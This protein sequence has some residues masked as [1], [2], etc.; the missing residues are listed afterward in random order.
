MRVIMSKS[1]VVIAMSALVLTGCAAEQ[2]RQAARQAAE[3]EAKV[4]VAEIARAR[5]AVNTMTDKQISAMSDEDACH[6]A[7]T[8]RGV[9]VNPAFTSEL[10]RRNLVCDDW[11]VVGRGD[12]ARAQL[13]AQRQVEAQNRAAEELGHALAKGHHTIAGQ[14]LLRRADR[15]R[16]ADDV[17]QPTA[18]PRILADARVQRHAHR[19]PA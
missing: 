4:R 12:Q 9:S 3:E 6:T 5:D 19:L 13:Q 1:L 16:P 17:R 8:L 10:R 2:A 7:D 15:H 18:R 11:R 14:R